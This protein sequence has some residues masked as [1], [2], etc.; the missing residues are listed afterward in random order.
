MTDDYEPPVQGK[1]LVAFEA[2][3]YTGPGT[4]R[5]AEDP[6]A[7]E[8]SGPYT[9]LRYV[10]GPLAAWLKELDT[11]VLRKNAGYAGHTPTDLWANYRGAQTFGLT[12]LDS[13]LLRFG[14]KHNRAG[15]LYSGRGTDEVG[16]SL[17]ETL[18]DAAAIALIAVALLDEA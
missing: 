7:T 9:K 8:Y 6:G 13:A 18:M 1:P 14:E 16:E 4:R 11:L 10:G 17:R 3:E 5:Y 12:A 15:I 2:V